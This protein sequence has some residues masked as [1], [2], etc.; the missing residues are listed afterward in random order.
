M[1]QPNERAVVLVRTLDLGRVEGALR[2]HGLA[3]MGVVSA[4][5]LPRGRFRLAVLD[6][7][8]LAGLTAEGLEELRDQL[9]TTP[10]VWLSG[11]RDREELAALV[12][13]PTVQAVVPRDHVS[14]D[15]DLALAVESVARGPTFDWRGLTGE[16]REVA[17]RSLK[18]SADRDPALDELDAWFEERGVR[19]R[20]R[21]ILKDVA[22]EL[23]TNAVYDAPV[24]ERGVPLYASWDRRRVVV[25]AAAH[26]ATFEMSVGPGRAAIAVSDP[27]GVLPLTTVRRYLRKGLRGGADQIDTKR[28]GAGLGLT[29]TFERVDHLVVHVHRGR[30]TRVGVAVET[31]GGRRSMAARPAGLVLAEVG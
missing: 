26:C 3:P 28:G 9:G 20:L 6:P 21:G 19:R 15:E 18:G 5:T 14:S 30:R 17:A 27:F 4:E 29:R 12:G 22:D 10:V 11:P 31:T 7:A 2:A 16:P 25:L 1:S 8:L 24:D 13:Y 23:I